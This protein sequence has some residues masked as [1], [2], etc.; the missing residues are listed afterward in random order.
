MVVLGVVAEAG[1]YRSRLF[2]APGGG[3]AA[4]G[5]GL[6]DSVERGAK[7][8]RYEGD[9]VTQTLG[10]RAL[11]RGTAAC[12]L[13]ALGVIPRQVVNALVLELL[14]DCGL[15]PSNHPKFA[16]RKHLAAP[17]HPSCLLDV[18]AGSQRPGV[19]DEAALG[20][21]AAQVRSLFIRGATRG[22][23]KRPSVVERLVSAAKA[24]EAAAAKG[25]GSG[26]GKGFF[27]D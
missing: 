12:L 8:Q 15:V 20:S 2:G 16:R 6:G 11:L 23:P 14:G 25:V 4:S 5:G 18:L 13:G 26:G 9:E 19:E 22:A 17:S 3:G 21:F 24:E 1:A 7:K 10:G 27:D